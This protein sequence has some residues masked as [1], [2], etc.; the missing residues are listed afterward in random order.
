M[1]EWN[2]FFFQYPDNSYCAGAAVQNDGAPRNY[3]VK[4]DALADGSFRLTGACL[5]EDNGC[6]GEQILNL[7]LD[8]SV[9]KVKVEKA[10]GL[11][12]VANQTSED[13]QAQAIKDGMVSMQ[14]DG[15]VKALLG[16]TSIDEILRVTRE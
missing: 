5:V 10:E 6:V 14:L 11:W 9:L 8:G 7:K 13:L 4:L 12:F 15:L 3:S 2:S 1:T 16:L